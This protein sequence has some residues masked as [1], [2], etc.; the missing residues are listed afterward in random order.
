MDKEH[1]E[2]RGESV[3]VKRYKRQREEEETERMDGK[4]VERR[5]RYQV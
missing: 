2:A 3:E 4:R 5:E 1:K